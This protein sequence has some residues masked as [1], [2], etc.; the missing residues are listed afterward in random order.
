MERRLLWST[1]VRAR[2]C[3]PLFGL[4]ACHSQIAARPPVL[5]T[6]SRKA[7]ERVTV[8]GAQAWEVAPLAVLEGTLDD[9]PRAE[10]VTQVASELLQARGYPWA[11]I[12][13]VRIKTC[14]VEIV[15]L[16]DRGPR[17][18]ISKIDFDADDALPPVEHQAAVEDALGTVNAI[19]GA[20]V[21]DRM[22]RALDAL[23]HHYHDMGWVEATIDPP[24]ASY[25][26]Q[27][28]EVSIKVSVH[29]GQ[30]FKIGSVVAV[31]GQPATRDAVIG[32]IGFYGGEWYDASA[33]RAGVARARREI[34][35]KIQ[36]NLQI[37]H[38]RNVVDVE[39]VVEAA[40]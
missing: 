10:R 18:K 24:V 31:G 11:Q 13:L 26:D 28:G 22:E 17:F 1:T 39:A 9:P 23:V 7:V 37:A 30:R 32:A 19:G 40:P 38:D 15:A 25:D 6:C 29:P 36:M 34:D 14:G 33:L 12:R 5:E 2:T 16:V 35:H 21:A 27:R 8:E 20:Y 4:I 3:L